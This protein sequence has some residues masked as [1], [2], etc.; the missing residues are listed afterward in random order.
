[1]EKLLSVYNFMKFQVLDETN[2]DS[3]SDEDARVAGAGEQ[4]EPADQREEEAPPR[5]AAALPSHQPALLAPVPRQARRRLYRW[6]G[7]R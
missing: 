6:G 1:M 5:V 7:E 3:D 4:E 2:S